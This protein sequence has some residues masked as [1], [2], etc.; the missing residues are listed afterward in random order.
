MRGFERS[1]AATFFEL[2]GK[3]AGTAARL[4]LASRMR[5]M[6][7]S[8][9]IACLVFAVVLEAQPYDLLLSGGHVIDPANRI[10]EVMD[11]AVTIGRI[12]RVEKNIPRTQAKKAVDVG[13]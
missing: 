11:V 3:S 5:H 7:L 9:L 8:V 2:S 12:A 1:W 6:K 4:P 13:G 10:N